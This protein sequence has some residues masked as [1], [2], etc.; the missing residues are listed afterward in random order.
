MDLIRARSIFVAG[1]LVGTFS[2]GALAQ[3]APDAYYNF[4]L[5][6]Q[7][8]SDGNVAGALAALERA[9]SADPRSAEVRAEIA[10][11]QLRRNQ[12]DDAEKA[13]KAALAIDM[14]N[15]E[16]NKVLGQLYAAAAQNEKNT[17][18]QT[19]TYVRDAVKYLERAVNGGQGLADPNLNFTLGRLYLLIDEPAKAIQPLSRVVNQNPSSVQPRRALAQAYAG[20][21]DLKS[22]IQTIDEIVEEEPGLLP[23]LGAY[24]HQAGQLT[25]AV[26]TYT[27]ALETQPGSKDIKENR[28][29]ALYEAQQYDKAVAF[30]VDAQRQHPDDPRFPRLQAV[31][32]FKTG[33]KARAIEILES[34][35]KNFS[36]DVASHLALADLY[37]DSGRRADAETSARQALAVAPTNPRVLNYL[38]YMLAQN[39]KD[40]DEAIRLVNRALQVAPG[41]G[42]YLDSLG[43]AH[44][45][46][47]DL[48]E[49]EKYI[50]EAAVKMPDNAEVLDHLGDLHARRGRWQD[51]ITAWTRALKGQGGGIEP[52]A[53]QKKIDDARGKVSR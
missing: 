51:A 27:K 1:L 21:N 22:A 3:T 11:L 34:V 31:S 25:E 24:Q 16:A 43:W 39:G 9:A 37:S 23:V 44:F 35:I 6:R 10:S 15:L 17:S 4:L 36:G 50:G 12:R 20:N 46:K 5:G 45:Q 42:A 18:A 14:E 52:S 32:T 8:E 7:L 48:N 49:A 26:A 13:A 19:T 53:V 28:I 33:D 29:L 40:L 47:G 41:E 2:G 38:G 30:A